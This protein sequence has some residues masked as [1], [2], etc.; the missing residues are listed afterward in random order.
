MNVSFIRPT[1]EPLNS[2][3]SNVT[4]FSQFDNGLS[5]K[6]PKLVYPRLFEMN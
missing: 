4:I 6:D 2:I 3:H 1:Y 5:Y